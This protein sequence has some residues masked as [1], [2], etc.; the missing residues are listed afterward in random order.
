MVGKKVA[1]FEGQEYP[2]L[3]KLLLTVH[4]LGCVCDAFVTPMMRAG[5][6]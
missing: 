3:A 1:V 2:D 6:V 5:S 4:N